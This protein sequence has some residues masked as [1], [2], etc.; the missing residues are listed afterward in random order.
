MLQPVA[1]RLGVGNWRSL[2]ARVETTTG[3]ED[4]L[5]VLV[6]A[7]AGSAGQP[8][9]SLTAVA[10][11]LLAL[12]GEGA[13]AEFDPAFAE[14]ELAR[15]PSEIAAAQD[16]RLTALSAAA[17]DAGRRGRSERQV[18]DLRALLS[19]LHTGE[20]SMLEWRSEAGETRG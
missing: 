17:P 14:H 1:E 15:I 6:T 2:R 5:L 7:S 9:G 12:T 16:E 3:T 4:P 10:D 13:V 18:A 20:K 8:S 11:E 19:A